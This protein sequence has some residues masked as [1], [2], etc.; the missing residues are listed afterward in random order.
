MTTHMDII[1]GGGG[2]GGGGGSK[3]NVGFGCLT[4]PGSDYDYGRYTIPSFAS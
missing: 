3:T 1:I 4:Y 2:A